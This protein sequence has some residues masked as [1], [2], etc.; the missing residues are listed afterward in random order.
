MNAA[1]VY[2]DV[3]RP[4]HAQT[5]WAR[6]DALV[7]KVTQETALIVCQKVRIQTPRYSY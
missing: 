3:I 7:M 4:H 1:L 2:I 5:Q 6:I